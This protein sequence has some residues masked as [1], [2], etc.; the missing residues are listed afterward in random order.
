MEAV[1][2]K[3]QEYQE[4]EYGSIDINILRDLKANVQ[5]FQALR[6]DSEFDNSKLLRDQ[7][8]VCLHLLSSHIHYDL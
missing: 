4:L 5:A 6:T 2:T 3:V 1:E 8:V 7:R